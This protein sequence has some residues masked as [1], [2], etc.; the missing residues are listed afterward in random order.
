MP[1]EILIIVIFSI[2]SGTVVSLVRM[3]LG[4][5]ERTRGVVQPG[6]AKLPSSS[7]T[8]SE[9]ERLMRSAVEDATA[10][11]ADRIARLEKT[12]TSPQPAIAERAAP[13]TR[14]R[15]DELS[16]Q[17]VAD[18]APEDDVVKTRLKVR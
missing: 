10:P 2:L 5:R 18:L 12:G 11:L 3:I 7:I 13:V 15:I 16:D 1:E 8:T 6:P 17:E 4:Y 14:A 9:L